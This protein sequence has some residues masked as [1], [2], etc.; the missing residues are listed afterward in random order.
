MAIIAYFFLMQPG[1]YAGLPHP[2]LNQCQLFRLQEIQLWIGHHRLAFLLQRPLQDLRCA[3]FVALTLTNQKSGVRGEVI[4]HPF[5]C[6]ALAI[7]R[8]LT[9]LRLHHAAPTSSPL[10]CVTT[11]ACST[12]DVVFSH[13]GRPPRIH[14]HPW[15]LL[16]FS[17]L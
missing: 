13:H 17:P 15:P 10:N 16:G 7:C 3:T 5:A 11:H 9:H 2:D 14:Y 8:W 6:P 1:E 12:Y 4:G